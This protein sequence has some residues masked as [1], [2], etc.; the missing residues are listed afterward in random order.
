MVPPAWER[1]PEAAPELRNFLEEQARHQEAW[2]GPAALVFTD[3]CTIGAKLDRN[4]LRPLRYTLTTDGLLVVGS[5]VGIADLNG[6]EIAER[7]RLGPGEV[8]LVNPESGEFVRP[9]DSLRLR[10]GIR[11]IS[12]VPAVL[13]ESTEKAF[14]DRT[15]DPKPTMAALGWSEDQFRLL[16]QPLVEQGQEAVWSMGDDAPPASMSTFKRPLWD[17]C[18][19]RFAQVTNPP[20]DSLRETHVMSLKVFLGPAAINSP[21]LDGGQLQLLKKELG[22]TERIAFTFLAEDGVEAAK[23]ALSRLQEDV[24][25]AA[26]KAPG[27]ILLTDRGVDPKRAA[28]PALLA[29]A[30]AW[31]SMVE[32]GARHIPL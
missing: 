10:E 13:V 15:P 14:L 16:F 19:Q 1:S 5:E 8:L 28:L 27:L 32:S 17:Y 11:A 7:Q 26:T 23:A 24:K 4:G 20:I 3:G 31:K 30:A 2:D 9:K 25:T 18:K 6:K 12:S 29:L 21:L 22:T